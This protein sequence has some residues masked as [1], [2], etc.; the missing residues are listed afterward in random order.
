MENHSERISHSGPL[1]PGFG[2]AKSGK[3]YDHDISVGSNRADLSKFSTLVA[4]RSV[5]TGDARDRFVAS[6]LES[7]RQV[8]RPVQLLDEHPRKQDWKRQ[9]QNHASSRQLDNGRASIKEQHL[10]SILNI[11][12]RQ[13]LSVYRLLRQFV[14][15]ILH[16]QDDLEQAT[17]THASSIR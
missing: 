9:M 17:E 12:T 8:E 10:V 14:F 2:W 15:A 5:I 11:I 1:A 7:G 16:V 13:I 3:K 6:Q 4:S